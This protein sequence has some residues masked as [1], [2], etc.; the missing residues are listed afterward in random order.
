MTQAKLRFA[1]FEEYLTWSDDPENYMEGYY[2]LINGELVELPPEKELN[3]S[4][5]NYLL[6]MLVASGSAIR[7][8]HPGKCEIQVPILQ[9]GDAANRYP[10]LVVLREEH[11][12][13]TERRLTITL[14]MPPP[15]MVVEVASS[16]KRNHTRDYK[17]KLAQYQ[18]I[19]VEEYWIADPEAQQV[20]VFQL[21][22]SGFT[23]VGEFR[24]SEVVPCSTCPTL[25]LTAGQILNVGN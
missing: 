14:D 2:E 21:G 9:L 16:G 24:E 19:G 8:V 7:L 18:E 3:S 15:R 22:R 17:N 13:L 5:A 20:T 1:S 6:V 23:K 12:K 11:L 4:I 25:T 10:D